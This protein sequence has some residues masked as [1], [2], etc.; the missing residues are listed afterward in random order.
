MDGAFLDDGDDKTILT[1]VRM[2][3]REESRVTGE[4][5]RAEHL[6]PELR[7]T[8]R[9]EAAAAETDPRVRKR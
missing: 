8:L 4:R 7:P 9:S 2:G 1:D 6:S 5:P 3:K